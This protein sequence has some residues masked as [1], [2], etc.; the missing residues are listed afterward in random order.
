MELPWEGRGDQISIGL[1]AILVV[2]SSAMVWGLLEE[3]LIL[4]RIASA[5][6][7][8]KIFG[9]QYA[10]H[11]L[12]RLLLAVLFFN[13]NHLPLSD[14]TGTITASRDRE[15]GCVPTRFSELRLVA[16][17]RIDNRCK[18]KPMDTFDDT[19]ETKEVAR[20]RRLDLMFGILL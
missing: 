8:H 17:H 5:T 7:S 12:W 1:V 16:L 6:H 3:I 9:L 11:I 4:Q 15:M 20:I 10:I 14:G 13:R 19:S 2:V 18:Q